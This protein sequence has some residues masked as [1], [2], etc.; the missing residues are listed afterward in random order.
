MAASKKAKVTLQQAIDAA[1]AQAAAIQNMYIPKPMGGI[2]D[3]HLRPELAPVVPQGAA[4]PFAPGEYVNNPDGS[5][6]S[7]RTMTVQNPNGTWSVLPSVWLKNGKPYEA[8]SEAEVA[9]LAKASK[10]PFNTFP[11]MQPA[12][13]Y[14]IDREAAWQPLQNP[15]DASALPPLWAKGKPKALRGY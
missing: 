12:E 13:Q 9:K 11:A 5:W 15:A 14:S 3:M 10:L 1:N 8:E 7:E 4:R 6:S 2:A